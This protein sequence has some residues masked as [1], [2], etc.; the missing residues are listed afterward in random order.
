MTRGGSNSW[1]VM[2]MILVNDT[3]DYIAVKLL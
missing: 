3:Y 1:E 2:R